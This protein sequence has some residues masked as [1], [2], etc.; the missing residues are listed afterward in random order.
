MHPSGWDPHTMDT[1]AMVL[2]RAGDRKQAKRVESA[3]V[4]WCDAVCEEEDR[5]SLRAS[6]RALK[7]KEAWLPADLDG[8][9]AAPAALPSAVGPFV[10]RAEAAILR[11][12]KGWGT[13]W[14]QRHPL[15][16]LEKRWV[17]DM[18]SFDPVGEISVS[19][20][21]TALAWLGG[22]QEG[23]EFVSLGLHLMDIATREISKTALDTDGGIDVHWKGGYVDF[24]PDSRNLVFAL[25]GRPIEVRDRSTGQVL[26]TFEGDP[27]PVRTLTVARDGEA[28]WTGDAYGTVQQWDVSSGKK[29]AT[30]VANPE[31]EWLVFTP[32]GYFDASSGGAHMVAG[33]QGLRSFHID[34]LAVSHNRPDIILERLGKASPAL[35][36]HFRTEH[37]RR[38]KKLGV[39]QEGPASTVDLPTARFSA[40]VP[41]K[42]K[43][44]ATVSGEVTD[45]AGLKSY[46]IYMDGVP[47]FPGVGKPVSG[48]S[49]S[50]RATVPLLGGANK[51][52]LSAMNLAGQESMRAIRSVQHGGRQRGSLYFLGFGVSEYQD[53]EIKDLSYAHQDAI[54]LAAKLASRKN[55]YTRIRTKVLTNA[56]VTRSSITKA[57]AFLA[58]AKP[59]DT[60]VLFVAGHGIHDTDAES[61]YYYL[62]HEAQMADVAGTAA[63]FEHFEA[64]LA[65]TRARNKLF[66]LDTCQSGEP[67]E[68]G[69]GA[70]VA[71]AGSRGLS[72][73]ALMVV[74]G[75]QAT[76]K[77][78][79]WLKNKNR[80]IYRDLSRRTGAV[81]LSS[82][83]GSEASLEGPAFENGAFTE[84]VLEALSGKAEDKNQ[85]GVLQPQELRRYVQKRVPELT[86]DR[87]HPTLDRDNIHADFGLPYKD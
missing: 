39:T 79:P 60:V 44:T 8:D 62:T 49:H 57:A 34:Q 65:G 58:A 74:S 9:T 20:D 78:R 1:F 14:T 42:S 55:A 19:S 63:P 46:Q 33:V 50:L 48:L 56:E 2:A 70:M 6:L 41:D 11:H 40:V 32:D 16:A 35:V 77:P 72:A 82:S 5:E 3:A 36:Q 24:L 76:R 61:T 12:I 31:G 21:G 68:G 84:A 51:I 80:F 43:D 23:G 27:G 85:D 73:R 81:V 45:E 18:S 30:Y 47:Q 29:V 4:A 38:K 59:Q 54:D 25:P 37:E 7:A 15:A 52:E 22:R 64:L 75:S 10:A 26:R 53:P 17:L 86:Q 69:G 13:K 71:A 87:Q 66:L 28:L 83:M 67:D